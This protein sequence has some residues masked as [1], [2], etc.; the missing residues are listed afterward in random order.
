MSATRAGA[1]PAL[2]RHG[3]HEGVTGIP[4]D[5]GLGIR[6]LAARAVGVPVICTS[7]FGLAYAFFPFQNE[8]IKGGIRPTAED[9]IAG[10]DVAEMGVPTYSND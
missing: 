1:Q 7:N 5:F 10:L 9:E 4:Y 3:R 8:F 6:R 2:D